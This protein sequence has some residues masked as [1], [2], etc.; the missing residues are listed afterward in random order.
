[1]SYRYVYFKVSGNDTAVPANMTN[2][3]L[4]QAKFGSNHT[5]PHARLDAYLHRLR[6]SIAL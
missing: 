1:M 5:S 3:A 4:K 2:V 6:Q